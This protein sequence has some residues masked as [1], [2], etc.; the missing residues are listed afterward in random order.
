ML[1][2]GSSPFMDSCV[3]TIIIARIGQPPALKEWFETIGVI[4]TYVVFRPSS[5]SSYYRLHACHE[6]WHLPMGTTTKATLLGL[7][8]GIGR[9]D[10]LASLHIPSFHW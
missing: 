4:P 2:I 6:Y 1:L 3:A 7:H 5:G 9:Y 10:F 8:V